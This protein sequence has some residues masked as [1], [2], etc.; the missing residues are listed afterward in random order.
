MSL[1]T[2]DLSLKDGT[3]LGCFTVC[4]AKGHT[5]NC[6]KLTE[7]M[8]PLVPPHSTLPTSLEHYAKGLSSYI[9]KHDY[10]LDLNMP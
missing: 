4:K 3:M 6:S 9:L 1:I 2:V 7:V 8:Q 5:I 10:L